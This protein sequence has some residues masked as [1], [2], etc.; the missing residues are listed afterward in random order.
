MLAAIA[1]FLFALEKLVPLL[2]KLVD[3]AVQARADA[4]QRAN[5]AKLAKDKQDII[6]F[7]NK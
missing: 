7:V 4:Q 1:S 2:T 3:L 6:D 5:D